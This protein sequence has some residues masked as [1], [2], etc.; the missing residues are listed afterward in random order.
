MV[1]VKPLDTNKKFIKAK[2]EKQVDIRSFKRN[3]KDLYKTPED[4]NTY[5]NTLPDS[6]L[7][8]Q[9]QS[10]TALTTT[11]KAPTTTT[12]SANEPIVTRAGHVVRKP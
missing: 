5:D 2:V 10:Q 1:R 12:T 6:P 11:G 3:R 8:Q 4:Y 9:E 7:I